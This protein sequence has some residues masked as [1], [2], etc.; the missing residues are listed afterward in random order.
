MSL[1]R[2]ACQGSDAENPIID[3]RAY[4]YNLQLALFLRARQSVERFRLVP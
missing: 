2:I 1:T 4:E 3:M